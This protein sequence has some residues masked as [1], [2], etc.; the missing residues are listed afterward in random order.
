MID[1]TTR[2]T[3]TL[4]ELG[5]NPATL[6]DV[7]E[8]YVAVLDDDWSGLPVLIAVRGVEVIT[9]PIDSYD[10]YDYVD[11]AE[12]IDRLEEGARQAI[13][14][15]AAG[16]HFEGFDRE[17]LQSTFAYTLTELLPDMRDDLDEFGEDDDDLT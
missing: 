7:P 13:A 3:P 2:Y 11:S 1:N 14:L 8:R 17:D 12:E 4:E 10:P 16:D 5:I 6:P 9:I 15:V